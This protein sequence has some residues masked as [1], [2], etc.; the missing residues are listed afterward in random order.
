MC[1]FD[2][3]GRLFLFSLLCLSA[4]SGLPP[5]LTVISSWRFRDLKKGGVES[6]VQLKEKLFHK[7]SSDGACM[8]EL[9][10]VSFWGWS[11]RFLFLYFIAYVHTRAKQHEQH[12][13]SLN[14]DSRAYAIFQVWACC[15]CCCRPIKCED[16]KRN[17]MRE[18]RRDN[19][20][21]NSIEIK[22]ERRC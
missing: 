2:S 19:K 3:F 5:L 9:S 18:K 4:T 16:E 12:I 10:Y 6:E 7:K 14:V 13:F 11:F 8:R 20:I 17:E 22:M 21:Y 1:C 15:C